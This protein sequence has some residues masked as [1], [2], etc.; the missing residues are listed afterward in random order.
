MYVHDM[1][2]YVSS[3]KQ[4]PMTESPPEVE[5]AGLTDN[6]GMVELFEELFCFIMNRTPKTPKI[7]Q[8]CTAVVSLVTK[9]GGKVRTKH[10]RAKINLA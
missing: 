10:L 6:V 3:S 8:D 2:A 4:K 9:G 1:L 7:Y 5:L